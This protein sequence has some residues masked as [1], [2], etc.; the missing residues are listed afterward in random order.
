M[1]L[2]LAIL[3]GILLLCVCVTTHAEGWKFDLHMRD[4]NDLTE[5]SQRLTKAFGDVSLSVMGRQLSGEKA[6]NN[7]SNH[8]SFSLATKTWG[9]EFFKGAD[10]IPNDLTSYTVDWPGTKKPTVYSTPANSVFHAYIQQEF[11][12]GFVKSNYVSKDGLP[13]WELQA[14]AEW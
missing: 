7:E 12:G 9:I 13:G 5:W 10:C 6:A 3:I 4:Y 2:S 14:R 8:L 1:K 11:D